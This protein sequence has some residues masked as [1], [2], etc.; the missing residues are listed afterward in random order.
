MAAG[1]IHYANEFSGRKHEP[2]TPCKLMLSVVQF[3]Q[4]RPSWDEVAQFLVLGG[5]PSLDLRQAAIYEVLP[6]NHLRV[7]G[8]FGDTA[9][10]ADL[11]GHSV[12]ERGMLADL[13]YGRTPQTNLTKEI[14]TDIP[15]EHIAANSTDENIVPQLLWPLATPLRVHGV[16]QLT[17]T[18][19]SISESAEH[20]VAQ[21]SA[22]LALLL[23]LV[24]MYDDARTSGIAAGPATWIN[25]HCVET[26]GRPGQSAKR[27]GSNGAWQRQSKERDHLTP[28]QLQVLSLMAEGKTNSQIARVL[29]FSESTVRQETMAI[30][31]FLMVPGRHEAV[32]VARQRGVLPHQG[33]GTN[34]SHAAV[35]TDP[36]A[37]SQNGQ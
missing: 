4:N 6:D 32:E 1:M 24:R 16:L 23:D 22:L 11:D 27:V 10:R 7:V 33:K 20:E 21:V 35:V 31:R 36:G 18:S 28:R 2:E 13:F 12:T 3:L 29:K 5:V 30:Y 26:A 9:H 17:F 19:P 25:A 34:H 8:A 14:A 15:G 37:V